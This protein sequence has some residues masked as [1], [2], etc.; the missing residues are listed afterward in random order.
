MESQ[1]KKILKYLQTHEGISNRIAVEQFQC[2][3]LSA[4]IFDLRE[5]GHDIISEQITVKNS[6]F[7]FY[8][9]VE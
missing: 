6:T 4:R 2:Y 5:Q 7:A 1:E 8:K 3:R 9:L